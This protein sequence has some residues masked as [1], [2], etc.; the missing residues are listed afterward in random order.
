MEEAWN[1]ST[2]ELMRAGI[3]QNLAE[4][5]VI[6]RPN[7]DLNNLIADLVKHRVRVIT[8]A[9]NDYPNRLKQIPTAP[10]LLY[11]K[12]NLKPEKHIISI[13]GTRKMTPYGKSV[14][15]NLIN[16]LIEYKITI[17]SGMA[18]GIDAQ[19]HQ[20]C[21]VN[22]LQT[23]A[24]LAS[25][26]DDENIYPS[27]N[28]YIANEI[29]KNKGLLVSEYPLHTIPHTQFF[30]M[31]NRIIAGLS[32]LTIVIEAAERS[33]SLITAAQALEFNR[34]VGAVPGNIYSPTSVGCN[35]LIK[36]GAYPI[37]C[38]ED[39]LKLLNLDDQNNLNNKNKKLNINLTEDEIKLVSHLSSKPIN[40]DELVVKMQKPI[41]Q[42]LGII[43]QLEIKKCIDRGS[44]NTI[45]I[46]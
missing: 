14:T 20:S 24:V 29:I 19:A 25:G 40:I 38:A 45:F 15:E 36:N 26:L 44:G 34:D 42:I 5:I 22:N 11:F 21:L 6:T 12:G 30:P 23:I 2:G 1:A 17:V 3:Q 28:R 33:G 27:R 7:I 41:Q 10:A 8:I 13:V 35:Q 46:K 37:T 39:I 31:R 16:K 9:D 32:D 18:F 43:T 4:E